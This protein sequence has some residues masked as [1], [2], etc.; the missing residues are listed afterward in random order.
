MGLAQSGLYRFVAA[1]DEWFRVLA[2]LQ[3]RRQL[4]HEVGWEQLLA[5]ASPQAPE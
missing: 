4:L 3:L 1:R 2:L 5:E